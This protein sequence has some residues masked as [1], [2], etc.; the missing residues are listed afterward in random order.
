MRPGLRFSACDFS[1]QTICGVPKLP[2]VA[3]RLA[4]MRQS[5]FGGN[6]RSSGLR[7]SASAAIVDRCLSLCWTPDEA[8]TENEHAGG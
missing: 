3:D 1:L 6:R 2:A 4:G 5:A 7:A 8:D